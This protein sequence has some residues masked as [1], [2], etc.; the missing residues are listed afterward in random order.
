MSH[1]TEPAVALAAA[2]LPTSYNASTWAS[3]AIN[4]KG[5]RYLA[6][7]FTYAAHS[8]ATEIKVKMQ[9]RKGSGSGDWVDAYWDNAGES[10]LLET[11][12]DVS[13]NATFAHSWLVAPFVEV[14]FLAYR[15]GSAGTG[16]LEWSA[17]PGA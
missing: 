12:H 1:A 9:V 10:T 13:G 17:D 6:T 15:D 2:A 11:T 8:D 5:L 16:A 3:A 14:R 7:Y 4:V